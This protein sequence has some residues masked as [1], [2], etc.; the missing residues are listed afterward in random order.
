MVP[1]LG[2]SASP[3]GIEVKLNEKERNSNLC[4]PVAL[5]GI[6]LAFSKTTRTT[7]GMNIVNTRKMR[8]KAV[9]R[10]ATLAHF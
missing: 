6:I 3:I 4:F 7:G 8:E 1:I 9:C 2:K 5:L 10:T